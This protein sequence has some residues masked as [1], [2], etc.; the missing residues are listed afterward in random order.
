[1]KMSAGVQGSVQ[2]ASVQ[3]LTE[4][5]GTYYPEP[6][7]FLNQACFLAIFSAVRGRKNAEF[8]SFW[9]EF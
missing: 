9:L 2:T 7:T 5:L 6:G 8:L 4:D 3:T 1:M